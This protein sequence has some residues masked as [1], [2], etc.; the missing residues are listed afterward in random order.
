MAVSENCAHIEHPTWR[1]IIVRAEIADKFRIDYETL[2]TIRQALAVLRADAYSIRLDAVRETSDW[3]TKQIRAIRD[4]LDQ[5]AERIRRDL[6]KIYSREVA[7]V[8]FINPYC[9]ISDL[10]DAGIAKRQAASVYLKILVENGL[11]EEVR[12]GREN[13][14]INPVLLTLLR[15][16]TS[17]RRAQQHDQP[18]RMCPTPA[19]ISECS[20]LSRRNAR[21]LRHRHI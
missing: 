19:T 10:V 12:A 11:L 3:S 13:L 16:P 20:N 6:P 7:E 9:R 5:T 15:D 18:D 2:W 21:R 17:D 1:R 14:Y 8:I 4:L